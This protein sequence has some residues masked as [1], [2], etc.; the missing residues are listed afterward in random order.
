MTQHDIVMILVFTFP[1]FLFT[2]YPG[3]WLSDMLEKKYQISETRKRV[4]MVSVTFLGA[5]VLSLLLYY[6]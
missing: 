1:M 2:V 4:V 3:I 5:L 6:I